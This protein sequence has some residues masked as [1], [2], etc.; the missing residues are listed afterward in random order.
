M[1]EF[2]TAN[3]KTFECISVQTGTDSISFTMENQATADLEPFFR[4][5]SKITVSDTKLG[6]PY[7][8][9]EN[10]RFESITTNDDYSVTVKMHIK[11]EIERRLD[12]LEASQELQDGAIMELAQNVGGEA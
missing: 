7:G 2:I 1:K 6:N 8:N 9:F 5:V 3:E 11:S 12:A 10:L 4:G